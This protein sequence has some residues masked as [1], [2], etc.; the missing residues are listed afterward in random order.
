MKAEDLLK[1]EEFKDCLPCNIE[2]EKALL[3]AFLNNNDNMNKVADFLLPM[4]FFLPVH[5]KIYEAM[6]KLMERGLIASPITLK[7]YFEREE[8]FQKTG[9]NSLDYFLR[10]SSNAAAIVNLIP[11]AKEVY[12]TFLR[13][14]LISISEETIGEAHDRKAEY[15]ATDLIEKTEQKLFNLAMEGASD[16]GFTNIKISLGEALKRIDNARKHG[17]EVNGISTGF[18]DLDRLLGGM[19]KSDLL[20][21]AARPSMGK[22]WLAINIVL[23]AAMSFIKESKNNKEQKPASVGFFSLEMSA[24]QIA[25]RLLSIKTGIDG[26]RIRIGNLINK[27]E[28]IKL[29]QESKELNE[30]PV[31]IDDTPALTISAVRTRARRMKRQYNLGLIVVDY[32]QLVRSTFSGEQNRVQEVGEISQGLKAI[33]KELDIPVL[34]LSQLS[35]AVETRDDKR[36]QLSDLR[37]SG[38]IEQ[39]ADVVM[40]IYRDEYYLSRK[41]P[42]AGTDDHIKWQEE[43]DKIKSVAD[44]IIAKQ[45]NGP[46]GNISLRFDGKGLGFTN[47]EH[48]AF[49]IVV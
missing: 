49:Q 9:I 14:S 31:Y 4:H 22:T 28:F 23:N 26:N 46:I 25:N 15:A 34:A 39:D 48:K 36:P 30:L 32:L 44:I 5:Q 10:L 42:T 29:L 20:I 7:N 35:R 43:M 11:Y 16:S 13:R 17:A 33:A 8:S 2:A 24:E 27:D 47:L 37:E 6:I 19:Q 41:M 38:N 45:R 1:G 3:G 21:L 12:D 40:F 18:I